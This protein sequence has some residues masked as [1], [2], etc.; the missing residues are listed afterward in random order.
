L[1]ALA[2]VLSIGLRRHRDV[3]PA[4]ANTGTRDT[5]IEAETIADLTP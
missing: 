1:C 3:P 5:D 2:A 4:T